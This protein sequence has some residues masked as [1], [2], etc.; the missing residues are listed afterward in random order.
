MLTTYIKFH[1]AVY[2]K[3]AA[4]LQ[5][6]DEDPEFAYWYIGDLNSTEYRPMDDYAPYTDARVVTLMKAD[7]EQAWKTVATAAAALG[8]NEPLIF[9]VDLEGS[10]NVATYMDG[11]HNVLLLDP[12]AHQRAYPNEIKLSLLHELGHAY[13]EE[14]GRS[15][16]EADE[17]DE[18]LVEAFAQQYLQDPSKAVERLAAGAAE[19]ADG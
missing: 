3:A 10:H 17:R 4:T 14:W 11:S 19:L 18:E 2:C 9:L 1:G 6:E 8:M 16:D 5:R 7:I 13:L 15:G 12:G